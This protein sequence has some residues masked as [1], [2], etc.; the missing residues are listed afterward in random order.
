MPQVPLQGNRALEAHQSFTL[1]SD[2]SSFSATLAYGE[3]EW[4]RVGGGAC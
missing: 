1:S 2:S 3:V 4:D